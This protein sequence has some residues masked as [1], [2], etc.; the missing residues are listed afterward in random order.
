MMAN[1]V[2]TVLQESQI[3][4]ASVFASRLKR[5]IQNSEE[6][7][8]DLLFVFVGDMGVGKSSVLNGVVGEQ[9]FPS[10]SGKACTCIPVK[11]RHDDGV[12]QYSVEVHWMTWEKLK[13]ILISLIDVIQDEESSRSQR[14]P[15]LD[16]IRKSYSSHGNSEEI[17]EGLK[18]LDSW[19][20]MHVGDVQKLTCP[21][22]WKS[23]FIDKLGTVD[24]ETCTSTNDTRQKIS[25]FASSSGEHW[26]AANEVVVKTRR[27]DWLGRNGV[28]VDLPG[29]RDTN[30]LRSKAFE[31][32]LI[33]AHHIFVALDANRSIDDPTAGQFLERRDQLLMDGRYTSMS[34]IITK[35]DLVD[36]DEHRE[37]NDEIETIDDVRQLLTSQFQ[38]KLNMLLRFNDTVTFNVYPTQ[39]R[40][41]DQGY[42]QV[43]DYIQESIRPIDAQRQHVL[44]QIIDGIMDTLREHTKGNVVKPDPREIR[45][46]LKSLKNG[47]QRLLKIE[48][49]AG[50]F[51]SIE[52][53]FEELESQKIM[54]DQLTEAKYHKRLTAIMNH[55]G[56]WQN[57]DIN[58]ALIAPVQQ[59]IANM[60]DQYFN[61]EIRGLMKDLNTKVF[62]HMR[63][64]LD[65]L[66]VVQPDYN[67]LFCMNISKHLDDIDKRQKEL[68]RDLSAIV[69]RR[70]S[71]L[72]QEGGDIHGHGK[73]DIIL[74]QI[75]PQTPKYL[76][77]I[78]QEVISSIGGMTGYLCH[79]IDKSLQQLCDE[80]HHRIND[81]SISPA[82]AEHLLEEIMNA[83]ES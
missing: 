36:V 21:Q 30:P 55:R 13:T 41:W 54:S 78:H 1:K 18:S 32:F 12:D 65:D 23:E 8:N 15:A 34:F 79:C 9:V 45:K 52:S 50:L 46:R 81:F 2:L 62:E 69:Q 53:A 74:S 35:C 42:V 27:C 40:G 72:Y 71:P 20:K 14:V 17:L 67:T 66:V 56:N 83:M 64:Y 28:L 6:M 3:T 49:P 37:V 70:L 80:L 24:V 60:W 58:K 51:Q 44:Q 77:D 25:A 11:L 39:K 22:S 29:T 48:T 76:T 75:P 16:T 31:T 61:G 7:N 19:E 38:E 82:E 33:D 73:V 63:T 5:A 59:R 43:R 68:S 57:Y 47:I 4:G 26:I 10:L